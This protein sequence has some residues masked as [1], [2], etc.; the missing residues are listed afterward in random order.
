MSYQIHEQYV[1]LDS[2]HHVIVLR[3]GNTQHSLQIPLSRNSCLACGRLHPVDDLGELDPR[4]LA[5][6]EIGKL[7][8]SRDGVRAYAAK[9]GLA[10]R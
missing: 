1:D 2:G 9:H 6:E 8:K 10:I 5:S 4:A 3:D 7:D